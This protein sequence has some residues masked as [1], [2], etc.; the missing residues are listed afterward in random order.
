MQ[1]LEWFTFKRLSFEEFESVVDVN[2]DCIE[3]FYGKRE[4]DYQRSLILFLGCQKSWLRQAEFERFTRSLN[5]PQLEECDFF[6][7]YPDYWQEWKEWQEYSEVLVKYSEIFDRELGRISR[8]S[9]LVRGD[10]FLAEIDFDAQNGWTGAQVERAKERWFNINIETLSSEQIRQWRRLPY[11]EYL[12]SPHW[13]RIRAAMLLINNAHCGDCDKEGYGESY[14]GGGWE[15]E[16]HVHHRTYKN[17][18]KERYQDLDLL[19]QKHHRI[20][21]SLE[22]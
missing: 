2:P 21:H 11:P 7:E 10:E 9:R 3:H 14:Y 12:Q 16:L 15:S 6:E 20:R 4:R 1:N 19:C 13:R 18:G 22:A 8:S 17:F 5:A